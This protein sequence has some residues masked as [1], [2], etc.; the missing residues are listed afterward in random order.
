MGRDLRPVVAALGVVASLAF[1]AS[2]LAAGKPPQGLTCDGVVSGGT[3]TSLT[4]PSGQQCYLS[5]ATI[6]GDANVE[7]MSGLDL[8]QNGA[9]HGNVLVGNQ[10]LFGE[11]TGWVIGG[12]TLGNSPSSLTFQGTTHN[13]LSTGTLTVAMQSATV[14]GNVVINDDTYG[15]AI[16][17]SQI[18]G[19]VL[20]NATTA[21][22]SLVP[23]TWEIADLN[24]DG[25][26]VLTNNQSIEYVFLNTIEQNLICYGNNPPPY[27][28]FDGIGNTVDGQS[29]GQCATS[30]S[31]PPSADASA[32]SLLRSA[33][34]ASH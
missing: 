5:N 1:S 33:K 29:L 12:T 26:L 20:V 2:A 34:A 21:G 13:I 16:V 11:G 19:S 15:G 23:A 14:D 10:S 28:D 4:V 8:E 32:Q 30:N 3:Y 27:N 6:L 9:I 18:N 25:N 17:S 24:I 22:N 31:P 7:S